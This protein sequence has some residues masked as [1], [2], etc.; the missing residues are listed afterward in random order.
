MISFFLFSTRDVF[1]DGDPDNL[2]WGK[3]NTEENEPRLD[4]LKALHL[5]AYYLL[6]VTKNTQKSLEKVE[7][8][9]DNFMNSIEEGLKRT[10]SGQGYLSHFG[11]KKLAKTK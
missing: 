9:L 4:P 3:F 8:D 10:L 2:D 11:R 5:E 6:Q 1:P 7:K